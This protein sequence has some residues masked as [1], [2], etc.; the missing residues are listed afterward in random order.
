MQT[1]G[2]M[3]SDDVKKFVFTFPLAGQKIS[4]VHSNDLALFAQALIRAFTLD[5][6]ASD[7]SL[8]ANTSNLKQH[9]TITGPETL[10]ATDLLKIFAKGTDNEIV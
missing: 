9:Y 5:L 7:S 6:L 8:L 1:F 2:A 3:I 10:A 4:L